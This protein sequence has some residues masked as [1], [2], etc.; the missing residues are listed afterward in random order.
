MTAIKGA[1][2]Y[3]IIVAA[4]ALQTW[5]APMNGALRIALNNP[6]LASL[7]SFLPVVAALVCLVPCAARPLPT[8]E[9]LAGMP[10]R[11]PL[12]GRGGGFAVVAGP[13]SVDRVGAGAFAGLATT[14]TILMSLAID[15]FGWFGMPERP[16]GAALMVCGIA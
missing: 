11:A 2:L 7:I 15:K 12:G 10:W 5:G 16:L 9:G 4:G 3:P 13:M 8:Q 6:W 1:W 14:A